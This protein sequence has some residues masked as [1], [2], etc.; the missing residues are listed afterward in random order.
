MILRNQFLRLFA[1]CLPM[2]FASLLA[3]VSEVQARQVI[4]IKPVADDMTPVVR[5]AI[6]GVSGRDVKLVFSKGT[7][8]FRPDYATDKYCTITNHGNGLKKIAF[9]FEDFDSV[10]IE[11]NGAEFIFHGRMAPFQFENCDKVTVK[12]LT[13]DWDIPFTFLGTVVECNSDEGWRDI[14]PFTDGFSWRLHQHRL[15]F[16]NVDGFNY[17]ELGS[18]LAFE[19]VLKRVVHGAWDLHS[20]PRWVEQRDD[21]ILR[22]H[23]PLRQYPPVGSLLSSKGDRE[24]DRY[25]PAFQVKL[26]ENIRFE[27]VVIHH[28]LGMGFLFERSEHAT[29]ANCGIYLREGTN[30]VVS[31]TADAT[32]FCNCRGDLLIEKCRFENMLDDGTNVHGTYAEVD[33]VIDTHTVR[34]QLKHFEQMGFEFAGVGDAIWFIHCPSPARAAANEVISVEVVNERFVQLQFKSPLPADLD[35]GDLLENKTWNPSFTMRGCTIQN[36]RARNVV[37]KTPQK[38]VIEDNDF[39][40]MMSSIFFRGESF[41]WFESGSVEDVVIRNNRFKH[42]AYSGMEHAILWITPR[43]GKAFHQDELYDRNIRFENNAIET[44]DNRIVWADR[45]DGLVIAG[46]TIKQTTDAQPL[47]PDAHRFDLINCR[48]VEITNNQYEGTST[49]S[50]QADEATRRTL[51]VEGNHGF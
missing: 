26:C 16:P 36:H 43:L 35:V 20:Q 29:L 25:A 49:K 21:G 4:E 8:R 15:E 24:H 5:G 23:E 48:N 3:F 45:V 22:F 9:L 39:S 30:R 1:F 42:C 28:A 31:T 37:L 6:D 13:L 27:S 44:F 7:Y 32:H 41:F 38:I 40:S 34:V 18:T 19:P 14:K 47:H 2:V 11:G 33:E 10:E 51:R 46:N 17:S 50:V 12:N